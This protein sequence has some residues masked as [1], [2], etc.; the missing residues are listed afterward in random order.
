MSGKVVALRAFGQLN[1][2]RV[3]DIEFG[4]RRSELMARGAVYVHLN[5]SALASTEGAQLA[6]LGEDPAVIEE[7]VLREQKPVNVSAPSLRGEE[8][9]LLGKELLRLLRHPPKTGESRKDYEATKLDEA[10]R[11]MKLEGMD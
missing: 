10:V 9:A 6:S 11:A 3:A 5:R 7:R 4:K 2:G 8:G 1:G